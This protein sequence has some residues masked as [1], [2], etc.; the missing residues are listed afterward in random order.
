MREVPKPAP[1]HVYPLSQEAVGQALELAGDPGLHVLFRGLDGRQPLPKE[2]R[3]LAPSVLAMV[4]IHFQAPGHEHPRSLVVC[5]LPEGY[6]SALSAVDAPFVGR[7]L[8][9]WRVRMPAHDWRVWA[10]FLM[11]DMRGELA[12]VPVRRPTRPRDAIPPNTP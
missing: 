3:S 8:L 11:V 5:Q 2:C 7:F 6:R 12:C 9:D 1:G 10:M 4:A